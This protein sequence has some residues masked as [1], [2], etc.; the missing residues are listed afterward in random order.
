MGREVDW[1]PARGSG[2]QRFIGAVIRAHTGLWLLWGRRR[3]RRRVG[4]CGK[5]RASS[6]LLLL[7][8]IWVGEKA[9]RSAPAP[10]R[11]DVI[12]TERAPPRR[13]A[14]FTDASHPQRPSQALT[15]HLIPNAPRKRDHTA[16]LPGPGAPAT[17]NDTTTR[18]RW[19]GS[20]EGVG[21]SGPS[22]DRGPRAVAHVGA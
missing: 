16:R 6:V 1:T 3:L 18:C 19:G 21:A 13:W 14:H 17:G 12:F 10:R 5:R 7:L 8:P 20:G 15:K 11:G 9:A 2:P 4:L 22:A